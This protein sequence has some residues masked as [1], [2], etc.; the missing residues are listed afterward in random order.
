MLKSTI[1]AGRVGVN[2]DI[3]KSHVKKQPNH[4]LRALVVISVGIHFILFLHISGLYRSSALSFIELS[5]SD[6]SKPTG[7]SIPHPR[8]RHKTA[9]V[10]EAKKVQVARPNVPRIQIDTV[11]NAGPSALTEQIGVPNIPGLAASSIG[12]WQPTA[13]IKYMTREDY[14]SML[15]MRIESHKKYPDSARK[16]Q[17]EGAVEVCFTLL[18]DGEI[19]T[20]TIVTPSHHPVLNQAALN[21]VKAALPF[22]RPPNNLFSSDLKINIKISFE[23]M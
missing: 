16:R 9:E 12:K 8:L 6:F 1:L 2:D 11:D 10:K 15:R 20:L 22:P 14:F 19:S 3:F 5:V 21:A 13:A 4:L 18:A 7:R 17:I 23:L